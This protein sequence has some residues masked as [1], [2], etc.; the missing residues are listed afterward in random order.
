MLTITQIKQLLRDYGLRPNKRLGQNFIIDRNI[1]EKIIK[2]ANLSAADTILEIG[3][4]LGNIT[5][6]LAGLVN[7]VIAVEF[8]KGLCNLIKKTLSNY[9][10]IEVV[11]Q[12]ILKFDIKAYAQ[13][14]KF[15]VLGNLPFYITTPVLEYLMKNRDYISG[16][17]LMVQKELG[18]RLLAGPGGKVYGAIS[19]YLN[20]YTR[21]EFKSVVKRTSF[22]PQPDVDSVLL[23][24]EILD[25][26][27]VAVGDERL[28]FNIIR[29][30][31]NQRRKTLLSSLSHKDILSLD[32]GQIKNVL[33]NAGISPE[34]RPES[35]SLE[36]FARISNGFRG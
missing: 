17:L 4:G 11:C 5:T 20:Y 19:C 9:K 33:N 14:N 3:A 36:E 23:H 31:F 10:T 21:L 16:A 24:M 22:F 2:F 7:N 6:D 32:K 30:A 27:P 35:L 28:F 26:P 12:D 18:E 34:R 1:V 29:T 25:E 8:D 15:K 13:K